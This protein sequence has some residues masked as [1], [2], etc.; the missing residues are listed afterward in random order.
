MRVSRRSRSLRALGAGLALLAAGLALSGLPGGGVELSSRASPTTSS[1]ST[2]PDLNRVR[3]S[4]A[5]AEKIDLQTAQ[6]RAN[7][8]GTVVPHLALIYNPEETRSSTRGPSRG[9]T[10]A[11]RSRSTASWTT[12]RSCRPARRPE[13]IVVTV[14]AAELLATEFEILNQHP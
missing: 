7:G 9:P 1:R 4:A 5:T 14:G 6:V 13:R 10:S 3:L 11:L 2:E 12:G 8:R